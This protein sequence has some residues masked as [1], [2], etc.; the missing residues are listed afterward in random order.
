MIR[1][2]G[3]VV[4][5]MPVFSC[6]LDDEGQVEEFVHGGDYVA[7]VGHCERAILFVISR[8]RQ[9]MEFGGGRLAGGQKSSCRST[10]ISAGLKLLVAIFREDRKSRY[11]YLIG[12]EVDVVDRRLARAL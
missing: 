2:E 10:M 8:Q 6:D 1:C 5:G 3:D 7:A 12:F 11:R 9:Q 4:C